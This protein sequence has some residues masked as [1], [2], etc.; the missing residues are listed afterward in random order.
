[1]I[2]FGTSMRHGLIS[3]H[4]TWGTGIKKCGCF[5]QTPRKKR[6]FAFKNALLGTPLFAM[7]CCLCFR[8]MFGLCLLFCCTIW[9]PLSHLENVIAML[10]VLSR[11]V[12]FRDWQF[13]ICSV[14]NPGCTSANDMVCIM[15]CVL[16]LFWFVLVLR[17]V[18]GIVFQVIGLLLGFITCALAVL[19]NKFC[20]C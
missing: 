14:K 18:K 3:A 11:F 12:W 10:D 8:L 9:M 17:G 2:G 1:M 15:V 16:I 4:R 20:M 6:L 19:T 7:C 5:C 13:Q